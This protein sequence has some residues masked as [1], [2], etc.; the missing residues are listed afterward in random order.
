MRRESKNF[1]WTN[2][3]ASPRQ[4]FVSESLGRIKRC[5]QSKLLNNK[6]TIFGEDNGAACLTAD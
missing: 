5:L 1:V 3:V 4:N 2:L 6:K